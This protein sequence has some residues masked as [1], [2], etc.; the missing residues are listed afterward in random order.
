MTLFCWRVCNQKSEIIIKQGLYF[1][2]NQMAIFTDSAGNYMFKVKNRSTRCEICPKLI[3][4]TT[5][6]YFS[7]S[8]VN[9][10][11]VI[12]GWDSIAGYLA[13]A[14]VCQSFMK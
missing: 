13:R 1:K 4:K 2:V 8:I 10:E 3:I 7:A 14:R 5:G 9:F 12:A 6:V 11:H